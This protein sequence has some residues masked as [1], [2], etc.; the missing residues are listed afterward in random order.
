MGRLA[1]ARSVKDVSTRLRFSFSL[2]FKGNW[3]GND[4][5]TTWLDIWCLWGPVPSK[6]SLAPSPWHHLTLWKRLG[7]KNTPEPLLTPLALIFL[8]KEPRCRETERNRRNHARR[9]IR[10]EGTVCGPSSL[11][12]ILILP[13]PNCGTSKL[14]CP[15]LPFFPCKMV[16]IIP[17]VSKRD[18]NVI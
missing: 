17:P 5:L 15:S 18:C 6:L 16:V 8:T 11:A 14:T 9:V 13:L 2:T 3:K 1:S 12:Y 7:S 4:F 10:R